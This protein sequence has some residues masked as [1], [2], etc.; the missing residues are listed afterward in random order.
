MHHNNL[1]IFVIDTSGSME[2]NGFHTNGSVKDTIERKIAEVNPNDYIDVITFEQESYCLFN[3]PKIVKNFNWNFAY[4]ISSKRE[5]FKKLGNSL[6]DYNNKKKNFLHR[7]YYLITD[8]KGKPNIEECSFVFQEIY[9]LPIGK[10]ELPIKKYDSKEIIQDVAL[11][12]I[13]I[14]TP[15]LFTV[16]L[17]IFLS[18]CAISNREVNQEFSEKE[19]SFKRKNEKELEKQQ[20]EVTM[21][22]YVVDS[23]EWLKFDNQ[24]VQEYII[25]YP[26]EY[27]KKIEKGKLIDNILYYPNGEYNLNSIKEK[28]SNSVIVKMVDS[29]VANLNRIESKYDIK[30]SKIAKIKITGEAD[31]TRFREGKKITLKEKNIPKQEFICNGTSKYLAFPKDTTTNQNIDLYQL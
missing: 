9:I 12:S 11:V 30:D 5:D 31:A 15:I 24:I 7:F 3:E 20:A 1:H 14:L 21:N 25:E 16:G 4:D 2:D 17:M 18:M 27:L 10:Y 6:N 26:K 13:P 22:S 19:T 23:S 28:N 29:V 8:E